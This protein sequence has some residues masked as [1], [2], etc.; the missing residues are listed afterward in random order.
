MTERTR[1]DR[2]GVPPEVG[3]AAVEA[4]LEDADRAVENALKAV[5]LTR[6]ELMEQARTGDF[7]SLHARLAWGAVGGIILEQYREAYYDWDKIGQKMHNS[8]VMI[9][10]MVTPYDTQ[11]LTY[12]DDPDVVF[13]AVR[14]YMEK[15]K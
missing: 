7:S 11:Y 13:Q 5:G 2:E 10:H 9:W 3:G 14:E 12:G 15:N 6:E 8:L 1:G 4:S